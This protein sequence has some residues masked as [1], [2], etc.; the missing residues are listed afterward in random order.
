MFAVAVCWL[1]ERGVG[2]VKIV[3]DPTYAGVRKCIACFGDIMNCGSGIISQPGSSRQFQLIPSEGANR[4]RPT[5]HCTPSSTSR[6][7]VTVVPI[8]IP[9]S[10]MMSNGQ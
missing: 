10:G 4:R 9:P 6:G 2:I 3:L 1:V 8:P 7:V 5:V